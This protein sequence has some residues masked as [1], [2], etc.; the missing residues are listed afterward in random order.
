VWGI[1]TCLVVLPKLYK[2]PPN[3][4]T[5]RGYFI[6]ERLIV[7]LTLNK[8]VIMK[9]S[10]VALVLGLFVAGCAIAQD[11]KITVI[12]REEGSGTRSAFTELFE[13]LDANKK[14]MITVNAEITN[15]TAVML[16]S[17]ETNKRAIGYVSMGSLSS[18]VKALKING[19][20]A[21]TANVVNKTYPISRPFIIA[22]KGELPAA[23]AD[24]VKFIMSADGQAIVSKNGYIAVD[25][26][27]KF[28]ASS[29][30]GKIV[31]AGSSSVSPLM[32][33]LKEAYLKLNKGAT[34]E[35]QTSDS[36]T[37]MKN[38]ESGICEIGMSSRDL[39]E[40][41]LKTLKPT[42]IAIDGLAV[43]VNKAGT[44]SNLTKEQVKQIFLG[45]TTDW[46]A[47]K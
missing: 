16:S 47:V 12:S 42:T 45:K 3:L 14:D 17:V 26:K 31:V 28:V 43:I 46:K 24:F 29:I 32:E 22:T 37:G 34:I 9:Q 11:G 38:A 30:S 27:D 23:A 15:N 40:S 39:K 5:L 13:V 2:T 21:T 20:D 4:F 6:P 8:G 7:S 10:F 33:K 19:V 41:E 36:S 35:I 18:K 44:V 25:A 1:V